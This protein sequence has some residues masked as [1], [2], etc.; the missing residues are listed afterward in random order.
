MADPILKLHKVS[1]SGSVDGGGKTFYCL[2]NPK[3]YT[4]IGSIVGITL[5]TDE[6]EMN[7]PRNS[8]ADLI[9]A[10]IVFRLLLASKTSPKKYFYILCT[11][12]K[13]AAALDGLVGKTVNNVVVGTAKGKTAATFR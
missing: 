13:I 4:G 9:H 2:L 6:A 8:V 10:G 7:N 1:L 11:R 5:V 3:T 12:D